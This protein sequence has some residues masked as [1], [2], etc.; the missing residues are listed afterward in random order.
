MEHG[1][2]GSC[3][4]IVGWLAG[5]ILAATSAQPAWCQKWHM[6]FSML[7]VLGTGAARLKHLCAGLWMDLRW[8]ALSAPGE[9]L[10]EHSRTWWLSSLAGHTMPQ[11]ACDTLLSM[12]PI[13]P[14]QPS[15]WFPSR[16]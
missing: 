11:G 6:A 3:K 13:H 15:A 4:S 9:S 14:W 1:Q 5:W 7:V 8:R 10:V 12:A 2:K 16:G